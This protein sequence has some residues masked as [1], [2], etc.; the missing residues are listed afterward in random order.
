MSASRLA[1]AQLARDH[2]L[3]L[4]H[5]EPVED[6]ACDGLDQV[7]R[8]EPRLLARV[9]ADEG[10]SLEHDV[11]QLARAP[12]RL[13]PTAQT[14]AP[15]RSHSPRRTGSREVVAV[16]T[17]SWAAASLGLSAASASVVA[18]NASSVSGVRQ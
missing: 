11:V 7:A 9:A 16:T 15:S 6:A 4:V 10:R 1:A 18:Q 5:L 12:G 3:Q 17:T 8:L 14:S 13:A 2:L